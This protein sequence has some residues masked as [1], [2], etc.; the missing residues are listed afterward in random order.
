[1]RLEKSASVMTCSYPSAIENYQ[2]SRRYHGADTRGLK[3]R[4]NRTRFKS[5]IV[6]AEGPDTGK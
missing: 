1:M 6:G 5:R 4:A 2:R 3:T